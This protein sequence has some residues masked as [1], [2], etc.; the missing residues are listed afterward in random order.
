MM[1]RDAFLTRVEACLGGND[2]Q[3]VLEL[4]ANR[5]TRYPGDIDATIASCQAWI[6]LG[7][8]EKAMSA[9]SEAEDKIA[10]LGRIYVSLGD[11]CRTAGLLEESL[12]Y[13]RRFLAIHPHS[14]LAGE[15]RENILSLEGEGK[16][17]GAEEEDEE[18]L[19]PDFYTLTM[20]DLYI[21]QGHLDMAR[22]VLEVIAGREELR[23]AALQRLTEVGEIQR[24]KIIAAVAEKKRL[25]VLSQL[26][27][28]LDNA[29]RM[30]RHVL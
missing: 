19:A 12:R 20:A 9:L 26:Q 30:K 21:R 11:I 27:Q 7:R 10:R 3:A 13:Y 6:R 8:L 29:T 15:V 18:E 17:A 4:S 28:W 22:Q 16:S 23:E 5:F 2:F 24:A 25:E 14:L 1:D